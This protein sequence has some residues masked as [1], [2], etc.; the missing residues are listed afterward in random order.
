MRAEGSQALIGRRAGG[1]RT[2]GVDI[3]KAEGLWSKRVA[4]LEGRSLLLCGGSSGWFG[5]KEHDLPCVL[6]EFLWLQAENSVAE[7]AGARYPSEKQQQ[8]GSWYHPEWGK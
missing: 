4:D 2:L 7:K 3:R 1:E 6:T 8:L 5:L